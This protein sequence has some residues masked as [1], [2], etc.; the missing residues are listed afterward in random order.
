MPTGAKYWRFSYRWA[1][2][3]K[4]LSLGV[5]PE[6]ALSAARDARD[7]ARKQLTN[8]VDPSAAKKTI[9]AARLI[10]AETTFEAVAQELR[11]KKAREGKAG[12]TLARID[13]FIRLAR[14]VIGSRP[15]A[16]L[17]RSAPEVL[18]FLRKIEAKGH[19]ETVVTMR[20]FI[21][22][23]CRYGVATGR[24]DHDPTIAI[25]GAL[26]KRTT[27]HRSAIVDP[28]GFGALLRA[29]DAYQ[30][31]HETRAAM[32][33]LALTFVRPGELR[34]AEWSEFSLDDAVWSIPASRMKMRRPHFVPL[35]PRVVD[36]L[37]ELK[38]RQR[39]GRFLF[40]SVRGPDRPLSENTVNVALRAMG[41]TQEQMSAHG[42]R[43]G[44]STML[45]QCGLWRPDVIER[46][47]SHE[48][49]D[50]QRRPYNRAEYWPDRVRMMIYWADRCATMKAGGDVIEFRR[51]ANHA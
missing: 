16:E 50:D 2:K 46:Q 21:G 1:G 30:G 12:T 14:P 45:N 13:R 25:R 42:F 19:G 7:A 20:G 22:E 49:D 9:K 41:F 36:I 33:L 3:Q 26:D 44:A 51:V 40:P 31:A 4:T 23:V 27:T 28:T 29:I 10:A 32:E 35:A 24:A 8:G 38:K 15:I 37:A 18:A 6:M 48:E 34:L 47:L 39:P 17:A 5:Y 11:D 43:A